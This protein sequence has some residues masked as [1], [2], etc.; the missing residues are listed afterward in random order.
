MH[1]A[2]YYLEIEWR[3]SEL[4]AE[5]DRDRLARQAR[6]ARRR[7]AAGRRAPRPWSRW[8]WLTR[9]APEPEPG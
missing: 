2:G 4:R 9:P 1:P 8:A 6:Q 7:A 5:A 3:A